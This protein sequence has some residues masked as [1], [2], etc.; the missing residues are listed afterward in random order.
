MGIRAVFK[1]DEK[2]LRIIA[3]QILEPLYGC[4]KKAINEW[5]TGN[6]YKHAY[7][8]VQNT[9][10]VGLL[11]MKASPEKSFLKISTL[12]VMGLSPNP[13]KIFLI[14]TQQKLNAIQLNFC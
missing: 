13:T 9:T 10:V 7:V 6:G 14:K 5:L 4:Q 1:D 2:K 3:K 8:Y 11:S 12:V